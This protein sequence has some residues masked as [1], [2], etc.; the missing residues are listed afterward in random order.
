MPSYIELIGLPGSGKSTLLRNV[1]QIAG[2]RGNLN[3]ITSD[4][5]WFSRGSRAD[6][7]R[8]IRLLKDQGWHSLPEK[9]KLLLL[10]SWHSGVLDLFPEIF[11]QVLL[12]LS[13]ITPENRQRSVVLNYWKIRMLDFSKSLTEPLPAG[14]LVDE[15]LCQTAFSTI[16]RMPAEGDRTLELGRALLDTL[17]TNRTL[18]FLE[19]PVD[20]I[21]SRRA[22][23]SDVDRADLDRELNLLSLIF[24][25]QSIAGIQCFRVDGALRLEEKTDL[26]LAISQAEV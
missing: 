21:L 13:S 11:A 9:A 10:D 1:R 24:E 2:N 25:H 15:G 14:T 23:Y 3:V 7:L 20:L 5:T 8:T 17:P 18:V 22:L 4:F 12:C 16:K 6:F 26:L 19:T